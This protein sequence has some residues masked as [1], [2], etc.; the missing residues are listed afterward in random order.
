MP[1]KMTDLNAGNPADAASFP[2]EEIKYFFVTHKNNLA[3]LKKAAE[4]L[5]ARSLVRRSY[6]PQGCANI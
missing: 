4:E 6:F 5:W 3:E 2:V 1:E